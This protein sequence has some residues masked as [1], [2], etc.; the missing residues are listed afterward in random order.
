ML[1][2][3]W[4]SGNWSYDLKEKLKKYQTVEN[5]VISKVGQIYE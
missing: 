4:V 2:L 1:L 3:R 5:Q